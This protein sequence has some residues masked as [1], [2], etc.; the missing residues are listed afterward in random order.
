MMTI[1]NVSSLFIHSES[2]FFDLKHLADSAV[3]QICQIE[4]KLLQSANRH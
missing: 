3:L 2:L 1:V 4:R